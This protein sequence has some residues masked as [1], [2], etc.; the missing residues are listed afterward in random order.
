M[1]ARGFL[2]VCLVNN[3]LTGYGYDAAGNMTNDPT[4]G[5]TLVYDQE[6]RIATATRSGV[7]TNYT[8]DSDG[9]RVKK[10][11]GSIGTLYWYMA[12]GIVGESDPAGVMKSEYVF[13]CGERVARRDLVAPAGVFYY[14]S[15]HLKTASVITDAAGNIKAE[16]DYYPWGGELQFVNNDSNHYKFTGKE[17][18]TESGLDY[19]GARYYS[20]G[21][22]RFISADWS[23]TP[24]P[25]PYADF[26]DPQSLNL[27]GYV[28]NI[29][30]SSTDPDGHCC[31]S[32]IKASLSEQL[33]GAKDSA[34]FLGQELIGVGKG[35]VNAVPGTYNVAATFIDIQL[36]ANHMSDL[37]L[38][39]AP[40]LP[41]NG[42][43]QEVGNGVTIIG[44]MVATGAKGGPAGEG[45]AVA[46]G[47][48]GA[49]S[50]GAETGAARSAAVPESIP[51]GPSA[52]PAPGQQTA[53][54]EMG[55]AH[56]CHTCGATTPGTKSGNWIGDHQPST[57]LNQPG[58]PQVY[59]PQCLGCSQRQGGQVRAAKAAAAK[60][61]SQT[62]E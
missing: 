61:Q 62:H 57:A 5:D 26:G 21:L 7:T 56:G 34:K 6:N 55:K 29:P 17:R 24:I 40:T 48:K 25:V 33:D 41:I 13:F 30:T 23:A 37:Q 35:L 43:G 50:G 18:D 14:F 22:G 52:R 8:Y 3:Q 1:G 32:E 28:R 31:W 15:D 44:L 54:N 39:L 10:V 11:S 27:Y 46:G 58:N 19:F 42:L 60:A 12:P 38:P 51:A 36:Q 4:D 45:E 20:N 9:N 59:K 16:S 53:I 49:A 2:A 47:A